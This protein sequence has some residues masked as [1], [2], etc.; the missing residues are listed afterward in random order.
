MLESSAITVNKIDSKEDSSFVHI[1]IMRGSCYGSPAIEINFDFDK[2]E[3]KVSARFSEGSKN[4][5]VSLELSEVKNLLSKISAIVEQPEVL[6]GVRHVEIRYHAEIQWENLT[7]I[8]GKNSGK[9]EAFSDEWFTE[10]IEEFIEYEAETP[11]S[12]ERF[13]KI[14]DTNPHRHALEI[15]RTVG[16]FFRKYFL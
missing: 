13:Q 6:S 8:E 12:R 16:K 3:E 15:Y 1:K 14:L 10:Q 4:K 7:F 5:T 11:E 9:F 2:T